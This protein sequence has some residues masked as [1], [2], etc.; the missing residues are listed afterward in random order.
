MLANAPNWDYPRPCASIEY[1]SR[2]LVAYCANQQ[3]HLLS[4]SS[5]E[6]SHE[7]VVQ[8][9]KFKKVRCIS[10]TMAIPTTE[11]AI[12]LYVSLDKQMVI[13]VDI[14][15]SDTGSMTVKS[16]QSVPLACLAVALF[17][18]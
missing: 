17:C 12:E 5:G 11:N 14:H 18:Y 9:P 10:V 6:I 4:I 1:R 16:Q 15:E 3:V 7:L 13:K 8:F 2:T